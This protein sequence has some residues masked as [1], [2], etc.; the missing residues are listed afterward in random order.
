MSKKLAKKLV[1]KYQNVDIIYSAN[2]I[3]HIKNLDQVF[4]SILLILSKNGKLIIE[5]P[6]LLNC[7]KNNTYDQFYNEHI[8]VFSLKELEKIISKYDLQVFKV[9]NLAVHGGST[10]YYIKENPQKLRLKIQ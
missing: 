10:R 1:K 8:Y 4:K 6:S 7:L 2:T 9:Q 5:D 3:T